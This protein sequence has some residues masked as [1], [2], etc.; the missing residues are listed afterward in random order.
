MPITGFADLQRRSALLGEIR[1]GTSIAIEGRKARQPVGLWTYRLTTFNEYAAGVAAAEFGGTVTPWDRRPGKFEVTTGISS[2]DVW[3]PPR[4]AAVDSNMEL[5]V[6]GCRKRKCDGETESVSGRP[7]MCPRDRDERHRLAAMQPPQACKPQTLMHV[8]L[9]ALPGLTGVWRLATASESAAVE[10]A[11]NG[12]I[13]EIARD[14]NVFLPATLIIER[15][16]RVGDASPYPVVALH[17]RTSLRD[18]AAGVLPAG[19]AGLLA[20]IQAPPPERIAIAAGRQPGRPPSGI[21]AREPGDIIAPGHAPDLQGIAQR[22][23]DEAMLATT[24]EQVAGL[25]KQ[26]AAA[27]AEELTVRVTEDGEELLTELHPWLQ[28]RWRELPPA[29]ATTARGARRGDDD[30]PLPDAPAGEEQ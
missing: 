16:F 11:D 23:A 6:V 4:G 7:C 25:G 21:P 22:I 10:S 15:R 5:W 13:M 27:K 14:A 19:P 1:I 12:D 24:Q 9:D 3:V 26:A 17:P 30:V 29:A 18:F 2:L 8:T 28:D 20:Q